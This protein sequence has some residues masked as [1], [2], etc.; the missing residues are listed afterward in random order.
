MP[1]IHAPEKAAPPLKSGNP[2]YGTAT[3]PRTFD[4]FEMRTPFKV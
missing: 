3:G 1:G 4:G 2:R